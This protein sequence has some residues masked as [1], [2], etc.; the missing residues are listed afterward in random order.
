MTE[1]ILELREPEDAFRR[2]EDWLRARGF[3]APGGEELVARPLPRLR[4]LADDSSRYRAVA[5]GAVFRASACCLQAPTTERLV[6]KCHKALGV[7]AWEQ[8]WTAAEYRAAV[9]EVRSAIARGDVYQVN[10]VQHLSAPFS[11]DPNALAARLVPLRPRLLR[12]LRSG[13]VGSRLGLAGAL[14]R[15][16]RRARVD[17]ADQGN[18]TT[19]S[20]SAA[21]RVGEG[22][23]RARDDRR[24]RAKRLCRACARRAACT[25]PS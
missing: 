9:E 18:A 23:R 2:I 11:G 17:D 16:P 8:T 20:G 6:T 14:S 7:G 13:G 5:A 4:A 3:F 22:C 15:T 21:P 1:A 25:G 10:L 24:P 12:A 19:R